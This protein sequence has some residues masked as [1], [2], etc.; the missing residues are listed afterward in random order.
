MF[1][2]WW[3]NYF[4]TLH[5]LILISYLMLSSLLNRTTLLWIIFSITSYHAFWDDGKK[6]T[7]HKL[8]FL[9]IKADI[10]NPTGLSLQT[11]SNFEL[12]DQNY[13]SCCFLTITILNQA[14]KIQS[15]CII[16]PGYLKSMISWCSLSFIKCSN[17]TPSQIK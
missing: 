3:L 16:L 6:S 17:F 12:F 13:F 14:A 15:R 8:M 11:T 7:L 9:I 10:P 4:Q 5:H 2:L 1:R